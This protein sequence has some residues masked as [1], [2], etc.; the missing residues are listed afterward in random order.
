LVVELTVES[1]SGEKGEDLVVGHFIGFRGSGWD[2]SDLG[3][4]FGEFGG[5]VWASWRFCPVEFGDSTFFEIAIAI[6][7]VPVFFEVAEAVSAV[8]SAT[9]DLL[10][11]GACWFGSCSWRN[12]WGGDTGLVC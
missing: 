11:F 2:G 4:E 6:E 3:I 10:A 12:G 9:G 5:E 7:V 1:L 8:V